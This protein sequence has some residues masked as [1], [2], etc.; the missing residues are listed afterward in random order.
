MFPEAESRLIDRNIMDVFSY[1]EYIFYK[2]A[3]D[4]SKTKRHCVQKYVSE[5]FHLHVLL[6]QPIIIQGSD[7]SGFSLTRYPLELLNRNR[8]LLAPIH[9]SID[10]GITSLET[11]IIETECNNEMITPPPYDDEKH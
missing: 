4:I 9:E 6:I 2:K 5:N 11:S 8:L 10:D 7:V 1:H 3:L